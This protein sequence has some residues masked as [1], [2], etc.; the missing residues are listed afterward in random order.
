MLTITIKYITIMII[1]VLGCYTTAVYVS[2][3]E[4]SYLR[5]GG[6]NLLAAAKTV[7]ISAKESYYLRGGGGRRRRRRNLLPAVADDNII[8]VNLNNASCNVNVTYTFPKANIIIKLDKF[9]YNGGDCI[10]SSS[11]SSS[12]NSNS[13]SSSDNNNNNPEENPQQEFTCTN[14]IGNGGPSTAE[15]YGSYIVVTSRSSGCYLRN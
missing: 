6:R 4:S 1:M 14:I 8:N 10:I 2:A 5:G 7:Y 11:S 3:K 12:S 9:R 13:Q 15:G